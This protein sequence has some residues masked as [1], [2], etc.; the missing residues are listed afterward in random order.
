MASTNVVVFIPAGGEGRRFRPLTYY[1]PKPMIPLG[2]SERP[3]LEFII[4]WVSRWGL[5]DFIVSVGY[6]WRQVVNYFGDGSRFNVNMKYVVDRPPY[7]N[8]GGGLV[9][10]L[11]LGLMNSYDDVLV[12]YG[13]IVAPLNVESLLNHHVSGSDATLVL[14]STYKVPVG[15][16][17]VE[18]GNVVRLEEKPTLNI[19]VTVGILVFKVSSL[20]KA[21]G[22][23]GLGYDFDIM[24]NL[25]PAMIREGMRVKAY[26]YDGP[27]HDI[28]S[29]E[30]YEK[31][32][33]E[34]LE[35]LLNIE[36]TN[37]GY[38]FL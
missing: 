16:A 9:R 5:R 32:D 2:K 18:D 20:E 8:T 31:V 34:V 1:I 24:G 35:K 26:I 13:D 14:A 27:W 6:K 7:S 23:L 38:V 4:S 25:I 3:V 21:V 36:D 33:H 37:P 12:W 30:R 19:R 15:V 28:G 11:N 29:I 22:G 10:A 17:E